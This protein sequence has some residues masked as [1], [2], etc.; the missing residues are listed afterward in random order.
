MKIDFNMDVQEQTFFGN[1][2]FEQFQNE[3]IIDILD[4]YRNLT[5]GRSKTSTYACFIMS[6]GCLLCKDTDNAEIWRNRFLDSVL[7]N[8]AKDQ[9]LYIL[10]G[11]THPVF[12]LQFK[13]HLDLLAAAN[14]FLDVQISC[15]RLEY[16]SASAVIE[17]GLKHSLICGNVAF[18]LF[19][20]V[21][22]GWHYAY[23][24]HKALA[25]KRFRQAAIY[26]SEKSELAN[27]RFF[28][29]VVKAAEGTSDAMDPWAQFYVHEFNNI[30]CLATKRPLVWPVPTS[31][32]TL[33]RN[34]TRVSNF[35]R[36]V[37]ASEDSW[38]DLDLSQLTL[39]QRLYCEI[40][41]KR[42]LTY[43]SLNVDSLIVGAEGVMK[44]YEKK[45]L[46]PEQV[47]VLLDTFKAYLTNFSF[48]LDF[49]PFIPLIPEWIERNYGDESDIL[50]RSGS[51]Q[52][53]ESA[54][55]SCYPINFI[56]VEG[57][58][59]L[60]ARFIN[61][62][63]A[64]V[65]MRLEKKSMFD[66]CRF[67]A[68]ASFWYAFGEKTDI[69]P[70][71]DC[72][73]ESI[74]SVVEHFDDN[75]LDKL[76]EVKNLLRRQYIGYI[77]LQD[78][79]NSVFAQDSIKSVVI[80]NYKR[81]QK[82]TEAILLAMDYDIAKL[83]KAESFTLNALLTLQ[84]EW[85]IDNEGEREFSRIWR[86]T[87]EERKERKIL[88]IWDKYGCWDPDYY[89]DA[90]KDWECDGK[91]EISPIPE[92]SQLR[93][94]TGL[95]V[96]VVLMTGVSLKSWGN[97]KEIL[98]EHT[99]FVSLQTLSSVLVASDGDFNLL[100]KDRFDEVCIKRMPIIKDEGTGLW[101]MDAM[102]T[103]LED[104][105]ILSFDEDLR[106][107][108][109]GPVRFLKDFIATSNID[110][111]SLAKVDY[112]IL[113]GEEY[114]N[115]IQIFAEILD[116][117]VHIR[118]LCINNEL[119]RD[120]GYGTG[121]FENGFTYE[122][123]SVKHLLNISGE[124]VNEKDLKA[125]FV[126]E[127]SQNDY[128]ECF[129]SLNRTNIAYKLAK[130]RIIDEA[131]KAA[132]VAIMA[133]NMSHN[134]G[135]H[136]L[137]YLKEHLKSVEDM[138]SSRALYNLINE[139][140]EL[141]KDDKA[142]PFMVGL[143]KFMSY[144]QERQDFIAD[145]ATDFFPTCMTLN[146]KDDIYD[147]LNPDK[148][149]ERHPD[150]IGNKP[151]NILLGN[152]AR[153][154]N[155]FRTMTTDVSITPKNDENDLVLSFGA[156]DGSSVEPIGRITSENILTH[157]GDNLQSAIA[158]LQR[159]RNIN[160]S[161]PGGI[162][163]R[164]A[165]FSIIENIIRNSA[166][167]GKI[168]NENDKS[169]R[170][171]LDVYDVD[172]YESRATENDN[173]SGELSLKEVFRRYYIK[174][175]DAADLY[176]ITIT[177]NRK[178][179][180]ETVRDIRYKLIE[181]YVDKDSKMREGAKGIKEMRI[182]SSWL[183]RESKEFY[184]YLEKYNSENYPVF[185]DDA[186]GQVK[187]D[188]EWKENQNKV[189]TL[190]VRLSNENL[191]YIIA[192][193][194]PMK[195]LV[196]SDVQM[197]DEVTRRLRAFYWRIM[198]FNQFHNSG[199]NGCDYDFILVDGDKERYDEIRPYV[200][201][202]VLMLSKVKEETGD[203]I[204]NIQYLDSEALKTRL[205]MI[206][207]KILEKYSGYEVGDVIRIDDDKVEQKYAD[208]FDSAINDKVLFRGR[209]NL[210][211]WY[212]THYGNNV[213]YGNERKVFRNN[214]HNPVIDGISGGNSTDRLIRCELIN[215]Q[216][217]MTHL[218]SFKQQVA[219]FDERLSYKIFG[220]DGSSFEMT[221]EPIDLERKI[222]SILKDRNVWLFNIVAKKTKQKEDDPEFII[223]GLEEDWNQQESK[224][225]LKCRQIATIMMKG[226]EFK[227][228]LEDDIIN[229]D[230]FKAKFDLI[231][232]HQGLLDKL[233]TGFNIKSD[234]CLKE[235]L[236][237]Q[238]YNAFCSNADKKI[239]PLDKKGYFLPGMV[240]HSGRSKPAVV[241]MPQKQPFVQYASL[242]HSVMDCKYV[243][244][245]L[246]ER[247]YYE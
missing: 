45:S 34:I 54:R 8:R 202:R 91:F 216:W 4:R 89:T 21:F 203:F 193:R 63:K 214:N 231:S 61:N 53:I 24:G 184:P 233:Y 138:V 16:A 73:S 97:L 14:A 29:D 77:N 232:I 188:T 201:M 6:L 217:F 196:I 174:A 47:S 145:V 244:V 35:E 19:F 76:K 173:I 121:N 165:F 39:N 3:D 185:D 189:P 204:K 101:D 218:H 110:G 139:N 38:K 183:R 112:T 10:N 190:Y 164:H 122:A 179:D 141:N 58:K 148:R 102:L 87:H 156:F 28:Q 235:E 60:S 92:I 9:R 206:Y 168:Y 57:V 105:D 146:F 7:I 170:I 120:S 166:K 187:S 150:R 86:L 62:I 236:T 49:T 177:D 151:D 74:S 169:L 82:E 223:Y 219:I 46:I 234:V 126:L 69:I 133:R 2:F 153:S 243:L 212:K 40:L 50:G 13:D 129:R 167:H 222:G 88:Y 25:D 75:N 155:L 237:R 142:M 194:K 51:N 213:D 143:G 15:F 41:T 27:N 226:D 65:M 81:H 33:F 210:K 1:N 124:N 98:D 245:E 123:D 199:L 159:L 48:Q 94:V 72:I 100:L 220:I 163:G 36:I 160:F 229:I 240:I 208:G 200:S 79:P 154:E 205:D 111:I 84:C 241:D 113:F 59:P 221:D 68:M 20:L 32:T 215:Y 224:Y 239:I 119:Y 109:F 106:V 80:D 42:P 161:I 78:T 158:D 26:V 56:P 55:E 93:K 247:C 44:N 22:S 64:L 103:Y 149:A 195:V 225:R 125:I 128:D 5:D 180:Y 118:S 18:T 23:M 17:I 182:C 67:L 137:A 135:S 157:Y 198:S 140:Y 99:A 181:S 134:L 43:D 191:Q 211:Y 52:V 246:L 83:K 178:T 130:R 127:L 37:F 12:D 228:T 85:K 192:L 209:K 108:S 71:I 131:T 107:N 230:P 207:D 176:F 114:S 31:Y 162:V 186:K 136:V 115:A 104:A 90:F 175:E 96:V 30:C 70:L 238:L 144:L 171:T 132:K 116:R 11:N 152:I 66:D 242:E 227:V 95:D 147:T 117:K 197:D 172:D